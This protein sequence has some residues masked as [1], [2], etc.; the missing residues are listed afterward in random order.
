MQ[1]GQLFEVGSRWRH[2]GLG[3]LVF[4]RTVLEPGKFTLSFVR[5]DLEFKSDYVSSLAVG[6]TWTAE[7]LV[8]DFNPMAPRMNRYDHIADD[9][10]FDDE[11]QP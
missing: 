6:G 5:N 4:I 3:H 11:G 9:D 10:L 2:K 7:D 1:I 8:R